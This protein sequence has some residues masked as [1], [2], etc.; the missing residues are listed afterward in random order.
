M[1]TVGVSPTSFSPRS[2]WGGLTLDAFGR[3]SL[4]TVSVLHTERP[5]RLGHVEIESEIDRDDSL[6][7][8]LMEVARGG[9]LENNASMF[10]HQVD[11]DRF[12]F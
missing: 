8:H 9:P 6:K 3:R 1:T 4:L 2:S 11:H 7:C 10:L 5:L 12:S